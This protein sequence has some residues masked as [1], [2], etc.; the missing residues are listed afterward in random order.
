MPEEGK[1]DVFGNFL[2]LPECLGWAHSVLWQPGQAA[3]DE[4]Y[5]LPG[6]DTDWMVGQCGKIVSVDGGNMDKK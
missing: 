4:V 5:C 3:A 2:V 6:V 1:R